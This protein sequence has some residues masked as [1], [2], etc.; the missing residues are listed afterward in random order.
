MIVFYELGGNLNEKLQLMLL[1]SNSVQC[2][3]G[4]IH[5][6]PGVNKNSKAIIFLRTI[7][8]HIS[9]V[10]GREVLALNLKIPFPTIT[11]IS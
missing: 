11:E 3:T 10:A 6:I 1:N 7:L 9:V 5:C 4:L 2:C 8:D